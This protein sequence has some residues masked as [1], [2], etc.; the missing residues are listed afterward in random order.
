RYY[1]SLRG[2]RWRGGPSAPGAP[3]VGIASSRDGKGYLLLA[4]DGS[5]YAFGDA[6][7][8][9]SRGPYHVNGIPVGIVVDDKTGGYWI[10][11]DRGSVYNFDAPFY[12]SKTSGHAAPIVGIAALH[13]GAGYWL[14]TE[15]GYV[16]GFGAARSLGSDPGQDITGIAAPAQ[17]DGYYLVSASGRVFRHG[18]I[19]Y[20]GSLASPVS[21]D[22]VIGIATP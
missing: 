21:T 15:S 16:F 18:N 22:P 20:S 4:G 7:Y 8:H 1:G 6:S 14:A 9:G 2:D 19:P 13:D 5:V 17:G 10:A 11:T 3:V 12:G